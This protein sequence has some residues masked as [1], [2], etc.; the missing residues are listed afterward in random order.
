MSKYDLPN[1]VGAMDLWSEEATELAALKRD[2][3]R[4]GKGAEAAYK[5]MVTRVYGEPVKEKHVTSERARKKMIER[6]RNRSK[7]M[8]REGERQK[9]K[10]RADFM[11]NTKFYR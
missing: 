7:E 4:Y 11:S 5:D 3:E 1:G 2:Q 10:L 9:E 6:D 8:A